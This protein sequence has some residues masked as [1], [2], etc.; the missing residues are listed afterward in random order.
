MVHAY[1]DP[2]PANIRRWAIFVLGSINF[3]LS[4]F[5]R[6]SVAVIA[7]SLMEE[8]HIGSAGLSDISAAFY[9]S[10]AAAQLPLGWAIDR[11][12]PRR[13][14]SV[15][16]VVAIL[17]ATAFAFGRSAQELLLARV[18]LGLGM[19]GN[20]MV[21]LT[22]LAV[23]FPVNRFAFLSGTAIAVGVLGNLLAATPLALLHAGLGREG[24]FLVFALVNT[25]VVCAFVAVMR[26]RPEGSGT[27]RRETPSPI[28][29][30]GKLVGMYSY[31]AISI[32]NFIRYG[33]F[34]AL[35]SL[36]LGPFLIFGFGWSEID[37]GNALL[38]LGVG[39]MLGLPLWGTLSDRI[40]RSRKLVI[41]PTMF[42]LAF[43]ALCFSFLERAI[44]FWTVLSA[45]FVF[46]FVASPGQIMYAHIK[47]LLP[48][49]MTAQ[50]MT[51]VN[52]FTILGVGAMINLLGALLG[53]E[54]GALADPAAFR[55]LWFTGAVGLGIV[56]VLYFFVPDSP[57][58]KKAPE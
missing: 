44:P 1:E 21:L 25:L 49:E 10:F 19:S 50:A 2:A 6:A 41:L 31:W 8:L 20:M 12:G 42:V 30:L 5:Y 15:L 47:E 34:A 36:W 37:A 3:V 35:Q 17:G 40:L 43:M 13:T 33:Y 29:G 45:C 18:L 14:M 48:P 54:P 51:S 57:V 56:C 28:R 22:L 27:D 32:S 11:F 24:S 55:A 4:M 9:Y 53:P 26:D 38:A 39:Y 52:L 7:P 58:L 23:W 46:G 16:G